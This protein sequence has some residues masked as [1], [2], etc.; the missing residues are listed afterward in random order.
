MKEMKFNVLNVYQLG[1]KFLKN[2]Y[3]KRR[4]FLI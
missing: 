1:S 3:K 2:E 4:I